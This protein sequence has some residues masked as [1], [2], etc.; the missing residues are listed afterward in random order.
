MAVSTATGK[1]LWRWSPEGG[2]I[3]PETLANLEYQLLSSLLKLT[4]EKDPVV[5]VYS[6]K[7]PIDPQMAQMCAD[8]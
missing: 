1:K 5:A 7:E 3:L 6:T 4:R 8:E 2:D